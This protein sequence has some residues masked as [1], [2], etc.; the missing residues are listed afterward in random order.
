MTKNSQEEDFDDH[1]WVKIEK[2][3]KAV[4]VGLK[5]NAALLNADFVKGVCMLRGGIKQL[6]MDNL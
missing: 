3:E 2:I 4:V 1:F 5:M 6:R